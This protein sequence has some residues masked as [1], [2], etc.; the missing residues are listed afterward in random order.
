MRKL[1]KQ[2][3]IALMQFNA[4]IK[5]AKKY[6]DKEMAA[7]AEGTADL[8]VQLVLF[9]SNSRKYMAFWQRCGWLA[10][11]V[12]FK[13]K[14]LWWLSRAELNIELGCCSECEVEEPVRRITGAA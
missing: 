2:H 14:R 13:T 6:G 9:G 1:S 4:Q 8:M 12:R 11:N 10:L 5:A 3:K 7:R